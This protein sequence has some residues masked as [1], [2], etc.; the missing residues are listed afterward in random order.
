MNKIELLKASKDKIIK[1]YNKLD[2]CLCCLYCS[3]CSNCL[4]CLNLHNKK[5]H[6]LNIK[7]TK[8]EYFIIKNKL[9]I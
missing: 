3:D 7:L 6:I 1:E 5:Y 9:N 2:I 8:E 4:Y